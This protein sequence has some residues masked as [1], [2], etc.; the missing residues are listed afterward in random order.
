M[1]GIR[2]CERCREYTLEERCRVCGSK[3]II[4]KPARFSPQDHYGK[5]RVALKRIGGKQNG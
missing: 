5:Y 3:T 1:S 4:K 2:Y